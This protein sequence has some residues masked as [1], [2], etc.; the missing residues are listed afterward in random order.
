MPCLNLKIVQIKNLEA[1]RKT[2][3]TSYFNII[4]FLPFYQEL[5]TKNQDQKSEMVLAFR[6]FRESF[7][8]DYGSQRLEKSSL[9]TDE[10]RIIKRHLG[11]DAS[12]NWIINKIQSIT[13]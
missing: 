12:I 13:T 2:H 1:K 5:S 7:P 11:K 4:I 9:L 3:S 6:I 10:I 8:T